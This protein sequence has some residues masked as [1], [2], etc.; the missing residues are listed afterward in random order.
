MT[1][2]TTGRRAE[3]EAAK[4]L[5]R[6]G[7][8][9][10][11]QNYRTRWCEIDIVAEKGGAHYFVEVKYRRSDAQGGGL[12]YITAKKL[13]QMGFAAELWQAAHKTSGDY[14]LAGVEI[15][16]PDFVVTDF[17]DSLT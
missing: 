7:F 13:R 15:G 4:F 14:R 9:V 17:I 2:F 3:A 16:G 1:T 10:L 8:R 5:E 11:E 12:E 6:R